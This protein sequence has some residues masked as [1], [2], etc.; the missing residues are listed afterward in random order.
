MLANTPEAWSVR[1]GFEEPWEAALWSR[2]GQL[3]RHL[4]VLRALDL[5]P[6]EKL[7]DFGCGT[8][9]LC[10]LLKDG[11]VYMGYDYAPGMVER[12]RREHPGICFEGSQIVERVDAVACIGTFNL[13]DEWSKALTASMI[14]L[15]WQLN[16]PRALAACLYAGRDPDCIIYWP[17]DLIDTAAIC[18]G[19]RWTISAWRDNDLLL[20]LERENT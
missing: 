8:G 12:A 20:L 19:A 10:E 5:R 17:Q 4:A 13:A 7:L 2:G 14:R 15:L 16:A 3:A 9:A 18:P 6:G 1:A 11:V